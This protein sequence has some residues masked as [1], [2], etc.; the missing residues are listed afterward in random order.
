MS[1]ALGNIYIYSTGLL[2]L[3]EKEGGQCFTQ[4]LAGL[5]S[6]R[7]NRCSRGMLRPLI[8]RR[9]VPARGRKH[10]SRK[11]I[12]AHG[13][14]KPKPLIARQRPSKPKRLPFILVLVL[15]PTA[16]YFLSHVTS[17]LSVRVSRKPGVGDGVA[18]P[19]GAGDGDGIRREQALEEVEDGRDARAQTAVGV[20]L[21]DLVAWAL[22]QGREHVVD[23]QQ[24]GVGDGVER[25]RRKVDEE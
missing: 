5:L 16:I 23:G 9:P 1:A 14:F 19:R 3:G 4:G 6:K 22:A 17:I 20:V 10:I 24:G 7:P 11:L 18:L 21:V 15:V 12:R 13:I 8:I 25:G 2:N